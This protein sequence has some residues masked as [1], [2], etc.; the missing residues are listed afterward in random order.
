MSSSV[1]DPALL[2]KLASHLLVP[3]VVIDDARTADSLGD[4][5]VAGA[6]RSPR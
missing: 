6:C 2:A 1:Q 4:A 5:L 3:V